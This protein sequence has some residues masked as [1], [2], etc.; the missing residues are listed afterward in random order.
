MGLGQT[1]PE[2]YWIPKMPAT[3]ETNLSPEGSKVTRPDVSS[4]NPEQVVMK[5]RAEKIEA[6]KNL[7]IKDENV[8]EELDE[9]FGK[10]GCFAQ[11]ELDSL[12][13]YLEEG[14]HQSLEWSSHLTNDKLFIEEDGSFFLGERPV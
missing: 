9:V 8:L 7:N 5:T 4:N 12:R 6:L 13:G 10:T 1:L 11:N 14:G 2:G 3:P